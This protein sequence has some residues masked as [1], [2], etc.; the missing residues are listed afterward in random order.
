[1]FGGCFGNEMTIFSRMVVLGFG[2]EEAH[3][4]AIGIVLL[5]T[6]LIGGCELAILDEI[7]EAVAIYFVGSFRG[8]GMTPVLRDWLLAV[9]RDG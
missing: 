5:I 8:C 6:G 3:V 1:M 9:T 2:C 7:K 4:T